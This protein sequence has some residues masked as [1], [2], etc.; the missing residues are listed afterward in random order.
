MVSGTLCNMRLRRVSR[1]LACV[2]GLAALVAAPVTALDL[3]ASMTR[4]SRVYHSLSLLVGTTSP[5]VTVLDADGVPSVDYGYKDGEWLGT[6]ANPN[7][8]A[9]VALGYVREWES[10]GEVEPLRRF[11]NCIEWLD[12]NAADTGACVVWL[13][14]SPVSY[15]PVPPW[16]SALAQANI[17]RVLAIADKM[18]ESD[19]YGVLIQRL[20]RSFDTTIEDGGV[21]FF[22]GDGRGKWFAEVASVRRSQPPFILN[23]HMEV[24]LR[25]YEYAEA[26]GDEAIKRLFAEGTVALK[27]LLPQYDAGR[28]S[29]YDLEGNWAYDYHYT[30]IDE[31]R[32][33]YE[34]TGEPLFAEYADRWDSY[35]PWNPWW[36][37]KRLAAYLLNAAIL[38]SVGV[39]I[40]LG[41][42][43]VCK[44]K[45]RAR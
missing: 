36:A 12:S 37:R 31:L 16:A 2:L 9:A 19:R 41:R 42:W 13:Y 4:A 17:L 26:T 25:L 34:L 3:E 14:Q 43:L 35:F 15:E 10:A 24:L 18:S 28:W 40:L 11:W 1:W 27:G 45:A 21:M 8:V 32:E 38:W 29:Y 33:L 22:L 5:G 39:C 6:W 30:H 7:A 20:L 44:N 23:G